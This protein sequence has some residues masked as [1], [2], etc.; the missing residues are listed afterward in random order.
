MKKTTKKIRKLIFCAGIILV[1]LLFIGGVSYEA[2]LHTAHTV[3][4]HKVYR[5]AQLPVSTLEYF[6]KKKRIKTVINMRGPQPRAKWYQKEVSAMKNLGVKHYDIAMDSYKLPT[7]ERMRKLLYLLMTSK[8]PVLVHCLGGADRS[9]LASALALIL[10]GNSSLKQSEQQFSLAHFVIS[11]R[12][13]GKLV[14]PYYTRWLKANS[15]KHNRHN[16]LAWMCTKNPF[17]K[18]TTYMQ[19][20]DLNLYNQ[21]FIKK[22]CGA[23]TSHTL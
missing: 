20:K 19:S 21:L 23:T 2:W 4:P 7:K 22:M 12:S 18:K 10:N 3:I 9:G 14:F 11:K 5:S 13:T 17:Q 6:A 1:G 16:F 8:K 15:L